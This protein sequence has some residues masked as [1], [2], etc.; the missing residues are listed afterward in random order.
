MIMCR[1]LCPNLNNSGF[2]FRQRGILMSFLL[3]NIAQL[4]LDF[5]PRKQ[6]KNICFS[7]LKLA[8]FF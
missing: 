6:Y 4:H 8:F 5:F 2:N 1:G 3:F 7:P